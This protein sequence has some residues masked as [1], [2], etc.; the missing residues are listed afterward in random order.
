MSDSMPDVWYAIPSANPENCVRTL[1]KW[2]EMGYKVAVL[3]NRTRAAI[4]ADVVVWSDHYP[5]WAGSINELCRSVVPKSAK[6]VVSGGDDMLPDPAIH[7]SQIASEF[8]AKFPDSFGVMQPQGDGTLGANT[9]C[10][11]PWL[12]RGWIERAYFGRG[13]MPEGYHHNWA[14][15]ELYWVAKGLGALWVR[16]DLTQTHE[17]FSRLDQ[18]APE[19]WNEA[20]A[21]HDQADVERFIARMWLGFPGCEPAPPS[22]TFDSDLVRREYLRTA[23]AYW[24][25]RYAQN[26]LGAEPERR[27]RDTLEHCAAQG[28]SR[29]AIYGTGTHTRLGA[30]AIATPPV[31]VVCFIEDDPRRPAR[32]WGMPVVSRD[33]ALAM[34]LDAVVLSSRTQEVML[35]QRASS[36]AERGVRVLSLYGSL[37]TENST[38]PAYAG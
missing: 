32:L 37:P 30:G 15:N 29:V 35:A 20:V 28:W 31:E 33:Q 1:P 5:G 11:S 10:G 8:L 9:F 21:R 12:G 25:T 4:P 19:Y 17:H 6:I 14:D 2:R 3:Q 38:H 36:L 34:D 22:L 13:P 24:V 27:L 23:E 16:S 18:P 7:A 26:L